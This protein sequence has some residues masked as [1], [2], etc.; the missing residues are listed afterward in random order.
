MSSTNPIG[1]FSKLALFYRHTCP[2]GRC[3]GDAKFATL[4][5]A[6]QVQVSAPRFFEFLLASFLINLANLAVRFNF[7]IALNNLARWADDNENLQNETPRGLKSTGVSI[8]VQ[9]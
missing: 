7:G 3:R 9:G 4:A 6:M 1:A 5:P 8:L 2:G